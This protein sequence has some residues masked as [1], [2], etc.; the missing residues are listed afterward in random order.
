MGPPCFNLYEY[1]FRKGGDT[2]SL[3]LIFLIAAAALSAALFLYIRHTVRRRDLVRRPSEERY[4][5][6]FKKALLIYQPSNRGKI[7]PLVRA[8]ART[9]A[10][11]GH[12]VT[13]NFPSPVLDY[14]PMDYDLLVFGGSVYMGE[15]GRPLKDYLS[16]LRFRGRQV[17]LFVVGDLERSPELA[18]LRLCVP[19][20]NQV[21]SIKVKPGEVSLLCTFALG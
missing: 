12:T 8:L 19:A 4:G 10:Q 9:L 11:A 20:G 21:R 15:V 6:G 5:V 14:N 7:A 18:S 17:L 1:A 16:S 13:V 3:W 2:L